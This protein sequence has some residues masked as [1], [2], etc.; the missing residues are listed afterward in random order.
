MSPATQHELGRQ[1]IRF[2]VYLLTVVGVLVPSV[3]VGTLS[4]W[5]LSELDHELLAARR[6]A[7]IAV[8]EH[9]DEEITGDLE[10]LQR[11]A[12]SPPFTSEAD[13]EGAR[14]LLR[15]TYVHSQFMGGLFLLD[16]AGNPIDEE[17]RGVRAVAPPANLPEVQATLREGKPRVTSLVGARDDAR[18]YA[19][20]PVTNWRG[21]T[22]GVVGGV[23]DAAQPIRSRVLRHLLRGGAGHAAIVD[24][25]GVVLAS[26]D[27]GQLHT[28]VQCR[29]RTSKLARE[30]EASIGL[31]RDCHPGAVPWVMAVA[32][33]SAA[34]W[35]VAVVQPEEAVLA[36]RRGIPGSFAA[37]AIGLLVVTGVFAWGAVRS[38]TRPIAVLTASAERIAAGGM[39]EPIP[40]LGT[41]ELGRLGQSVERMRSSLRDMIAYVHEANEELE[42]RVAERTRELAQANE[43]LRD[44]DAQHQRLLRMVITAQEDERK[45][46]ARELHDET[47]QSLAV[48]VMGIE[49]AAQAIRAGGPMPRLDE[50]KALA[51][52][53]LEEVHRLILDLRPAVLDDLGLASALRWY[54]ERCLGS[55]GIAVRCEIAELERRLAPEVEIALFR[56]GQEA[57]NNIARHARAESVLIQMESD[58][59]ELRIEIE[60]D[61]QGF[62]VGTAPTDRPH[63]GLLGIQERAELLGGRA[64]IES[65]PGAGTRL[66]IRV[67]IPDRPSSPEPAPRLSSV[68]P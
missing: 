12:S 10:A 1:G 3:L 46:I 37:I 8:A 6:G 60:D 28:P 31:C 4:W 9:L 7:S 36:S 61:G 65:A 34:P 59:R 66:E 51:V 48:L 64:T 17:P 54:A 50:G 27:R 15:T 63:Y 18:T 25:N 21:K 42:Q 39:D 44:R 30:K 5:H 11:L 38:V 52:R 40:D 45:R 68:T 2:R 35:A 49:S 16:R 23:I 14:A 19:L 53:T 55:R 13:P 67:P 41:D 62:V 43:Q 26:T 58:G 32:P 29:A 22:I 33:L 47:T 20:V 56:I 24:A 57:M